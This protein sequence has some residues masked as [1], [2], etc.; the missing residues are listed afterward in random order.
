VELGACNGVEH[1]VEH[2]LELGVELGVELGLLA[3]ATDAEEHAAAH[4]MGVFSAAAAAYSV[5][6]APVCTNEL[7][8]WGV[9]ICIRFC[10][11]P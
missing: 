10:V 3:T 9:C 7:L 4:T 5:Y 8:L 6:C 11:C 1:G 2:G